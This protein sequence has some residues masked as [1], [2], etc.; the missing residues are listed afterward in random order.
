MAVTTCTVTGPWEHVCGTR[1]EN[2][3]RLID[4]CNMN[5]LVIGRTLFQ[6]QDIH[7]LTETSTS[8]QI[9]HLMI[10]ST[11]KRSL[12]DVRVTRGADVG[13]DHHF[14]TAFIKL[15]LR[16]A[17][18]R[19]TALRCF[20]TEKLR[21]PSAFVLQVQN[22]FQALQN[23]E[24]EAVHPETEINRV[25]FVCKESSEE[26]WSSGREGRGKNG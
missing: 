9:D 24:E 12:L 18:R 17:G 13:G 25:A 10:S 16:S 19:M 11:W 15:K 4:L 26:A 22:R 7:K 2:G 8:Y 3:E 5:N 20:D 6:Y 21:D 23:L 14:L 1:N